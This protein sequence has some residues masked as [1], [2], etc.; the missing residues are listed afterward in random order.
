MDPSTQ[1]ALRELPAVDELL[2]LTESQGREHPEPRWA[3]VAA[4]RELIAER[5]RRILAGE[6]SDGELSVDDVVNAAKRYLVETGRTTVTMA[7]A[8]KGGDK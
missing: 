3:L 5:R 8:D 2:L 6:S 4:C 7:P 1:R